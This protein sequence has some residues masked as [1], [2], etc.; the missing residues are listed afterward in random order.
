M[1]PIDQINLA[2]KDN[3]IHQECKNLKEYM[4]KHTILIKPK[5]LP[6]KKKIKIKSILDK[7]SILKRDSISIRII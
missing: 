3:H 2:L 4:N 7:V 5:R 6:I 1:R